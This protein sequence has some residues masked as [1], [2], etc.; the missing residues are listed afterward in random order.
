V[1]KL[2]NQGILLNSGVI[3]E[4]GDVNHVTNLYLMSNQQFNASVNLDNYLSRK[5]NGLYRFKN[6][7]I[8]NKKGE[9]CQSFSIGDDIYI[10]F[11]IEQFQKMKRPKMAVK[12]RTADGIPLCNMV[13]NDSGFQLNDLKK[14]ENITVTLKD[15]RL[16]PGSYYISL[17]IGS[18][19]SVDIFDYV[20]DCLVFNIV[21][22]GKLTARRL[23]KEAGLLFLTPEWRKMIG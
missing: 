8:L 19:D 4:Y 16:Y 21:D 22:G 12:L 18:S 20:E 1:N 2:C 11:K 9:I 7:V 23:P 14:I 6:A 10:S 15:I 13:D 3:E 5:G 17:W